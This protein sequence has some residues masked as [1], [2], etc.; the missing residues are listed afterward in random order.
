MD[1]VDTRPEFVEIDNEKLRGSMCKRDARK[2]DVEI[3][4]PQI[5]HQFGPKS[6]T[7]LGILHAFIPI[8]IQT[9]AD[10]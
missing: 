9:V 7:G 5:P 2:T 6:I 3:R 1:F 10:G 8:D 4:A